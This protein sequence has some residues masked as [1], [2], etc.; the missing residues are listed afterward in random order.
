MQQ[1]IGIKKQAGLQAGNRI[2]SRGANSSGLRSNTDEKRKRYIRDTD[3]AF[4]IS[5]LIIYRCEP[6]EDHL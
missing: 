3:S 1:R 6:A 2:R 5:I 4:Y